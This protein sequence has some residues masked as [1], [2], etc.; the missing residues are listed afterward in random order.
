MC[1]VHFADIYNIL[2]INAHMFNTKVCLKT[3]IRF[4]A[5]IHHLQSPSVTTKLHAVININ[6]FYIIVILHVTC[7]YVNYCM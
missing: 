5:S 6:R 2:P 3:S 7:L 1:T 4:D